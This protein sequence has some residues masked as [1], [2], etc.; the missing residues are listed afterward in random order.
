MPFDGRVVSDDE[1]IEEVKQAV[2]EA[3]LRGELMCDHA[4]VVEQSATMR[5]VDGALYVCVLGAYWQKFGRW[6]LSATARWFAIRLAVRHERLFLALK[7]NPQLCQRETR[8][9]D[10]MMEP[11]A[12][13][14]AAVPI[15]IWTR[16]VTGRRQP[17]HDT[18]DAG[19]GKAGED[20]PQG[21]GA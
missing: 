15:E 12:G 7:D 21:T 9:F 20:V 13:A 3:R 17:R 14:G 18:D 11:S 2:R 5:D 10:E 4:D 6:P 8:A 1:E 16:R 19:D